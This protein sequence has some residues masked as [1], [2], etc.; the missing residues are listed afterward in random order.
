[1][2]NP[3][4]R[5]EAAG[6]EDE[7]SGRFF[8]GHIGQMRGVRA[9]VAADHQHQVGRGNQHFEQGILPLLGCPANGVENAEVVIRPVAR[10]HR[11]T[12]T[13]LHLLGFG[14]QHGRL[15]GDADFLQM[16]IR[17]ESLGACVA[18]LGQKF[19]SVAALAQIGT[20]RVRFREVVHDQK[21]TGAAC[22]PRP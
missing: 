2:A 16:H 19:F 11:R 13:P 1:M 4:R 5:L 10:Q 7:V 14:A 3:V 15:V 18:E 22:R 9:V 20:D 6:I 8:L 12:Q 17:I 21:V